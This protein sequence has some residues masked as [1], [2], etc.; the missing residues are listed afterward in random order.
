MKRVLL[1]MLAC[2]VLPAGVSAQTNKPPTPES[3]ASAQKSE[4]S[5][6]E[7]VEAQKLSLEVVK[8][9]KAGKYD[10]AT[11]PAKR[12]LQLREKV[13]PPGHDLI[14]SSLINLGELYR[15]RGKYGDAKVYHQRLLAIY[16]Q[17]PAQD[18]AAI[19]SVS[20]R[21]AY[22]NYMEFEFDEAEKLYQRALALREQAHGAESL[23]V[24]KSLFNLGEFYRLR[25]E[26]LKAEPYY[27]RSIE[28][29]GNALGPDD[30]DV[31]KA[32][33]RYSCLYYELN[34][35]DKLK[36]IRGRFS[37]LRKKD[38]AR[39]D[40]GEVLNGKAISLPKPNFP[41]IGR[42]DRL[43]ATVVIKVKID[44]RGNVIGTEDM[45]SAHPYFLQAAIEA[46]TK[47]RFTPTIL[48]GAPV[49]VTGIITYR[50]AGR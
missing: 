15:A 30:P 40:K 31:V 44:E 36:E 38:E 29:R 19:A 27:Q 10:E 37:F 45:C 23:E 26:H 42:R 17:A 41:I 20:D 39:L 3:Q 1:A 47:A 11:P 2:A 8:L 48:S 6:P 32:L 22:L 25:G 4:S 7:L 35:T 34:K 50:F 24:S 13:L 16:E 43:S 9:F 21:L 46:A 14:Q 49:K 12:A 18:R 33:D 5:S 28:I